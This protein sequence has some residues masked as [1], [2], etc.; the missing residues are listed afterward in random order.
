MKEIIL[1]SLHTSFMMFVFIEWSLYVHDRQ[2]GKRK[3]EK[4]MGTLSEYDT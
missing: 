4:A 3:V 1:A 2:M